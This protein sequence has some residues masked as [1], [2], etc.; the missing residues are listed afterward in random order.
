MINTGASDVG[1]PDVSNEHPS[2]DFSFDPK[3]H[4]DQWFKQ[5]ETFRYRIP[6]EPTPRISLNGEDLDFEGVV[7]FE[8]KLRRKLDTEGTLIVAEHGKLEGNVE[9]TLALIDGVFKGNITATEGV[10]VENHAVVIGDIDTP[11]LTIRGGAII[12]GRCQFTPREKWGPP[13][14]SALKG[15]LAKVWRNR[16][17]Q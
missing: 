15:G 9:V 17:F 5:V 10:V 11:A 3:A 2:T 16:I 8:S 4:F 12:E 13:V 1:S 14:W 6:A 7:N